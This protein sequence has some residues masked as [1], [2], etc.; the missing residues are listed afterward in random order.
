MTDLLQLTINILKSHHQPQCVLQLVCE[1]SVSSSDLIF[2][3]IYAGS[4]IQNAIE[5]FVSC[6]HISFLN[7][8][9]H[10]NAQTKI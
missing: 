3:L 7:F 1:A 4:S 10:P 6:I 9:L 5:R 2:T 8:A